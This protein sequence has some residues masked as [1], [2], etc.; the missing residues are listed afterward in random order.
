MADEDNI[1]NEIR[2]SLRNLRT[3]RFN[4]Q[5]ARQQLIAATRQVNQAQLTLRQQQG[6]D[7]SQTQDLLQA[8]DQLRGA[9]NNLI[10]DWINYETSRIELFVNLE[11][12]ELNEQGVW[13]NEQENF[14][15]FR[16][17]DTGVSDSAPA[18]DIAPEDDSQSPPLPEEV[19]RPE[20]EG[21]SAKKPFSYY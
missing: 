18:V 3:N 20:F 13:I 12:L 4:F 15:R 2:L 19:P 11:L 16:S 8:L 9:K 17:I 6:T 7:S 14:D 5:I 10:S 21:S 1:V